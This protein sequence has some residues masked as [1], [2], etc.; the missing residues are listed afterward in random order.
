M[1]GTAPDPDPVLDQFP[2]PFAPMPVQAKVNPEDD[3]EMDWF[4]GREKAELEAEQYERDFR[5][6]NGAKF[7]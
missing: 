5:N 1:T 7:T 3:Y 2:N 4:R 6:W